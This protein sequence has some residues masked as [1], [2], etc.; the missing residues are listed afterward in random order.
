M[1]V[2]RAPMRSRRD[3]VEPWLAVERALAL[4]LC[5]MGEVTDDRSAR[6]LERFAAVPD[7]SFVWTRD[8]DGSTYLGRLRGPCRRD[9]APDAVRADLVHVRDCTWLPDPVA[10]ADIPAAVTLTFERGG[11]NFQQ[12]HHPTVESETAALWA[13]AQSVQNGSDPGAGQPERTD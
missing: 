13:D 11:R 7:D 5:G 1:G 10:P 2:Y 6:R 8:G 9:E 4:G 3:D 12:T